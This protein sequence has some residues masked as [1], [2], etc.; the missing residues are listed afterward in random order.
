MTHRTENQIKNEISQLELGRSLPG[1]HP[2]IARRFEAR[3]HELK[4]ELRE[5][6]DTPILPYR[7]PSSTP[8]APRGRKRPPAIPPAA[9]IPSEKKP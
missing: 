1:V 9:R 7:P 3:I 6:D 4:R 2:E 5:I 8:S